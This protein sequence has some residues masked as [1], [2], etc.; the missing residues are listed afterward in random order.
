MKA[1]GSKFCKL[2]GRVTSDVSF[3]AIARP[4]AYLYRHI[5]SRQL[6]M[7]VDC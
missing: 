2:P 7:P 1:K 5:C 3:C 4:A 6:D